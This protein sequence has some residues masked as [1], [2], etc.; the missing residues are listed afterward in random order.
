MR[1][2]GQVTIFLSMILLCMC[3]LLCSI[4]ESA[5]MAGA[6]WYLRMAADSALDSVM[7][8]YHRELWDSYRLLFREFGQPE[9]LEEEFTRYFQPCIGYG[10]WYSGEIEGIDVKLAAMAV[11]EGG[12]FLEEEILDYMKFGIWTMELSPEET[13]D[14]KERLKEAQAVGR[15][16]EIYSAHTREAVK[17]EEALE[18]LDSCLMKQKEKKSQGLEALADGDGGR[19]QRIGRELLKE[20]ERVPRLV[21]TYEKRADDLDRKLARSMARF[22]GESEDM[23]DEAIKLLEQEIGR[24]ESYI[25]KDGERRK[26]IEG[27]IAI[28]EQNRALTEAVMEE[29]EAVEEYIENW[30]GDDEEDELDEEALWRPVRNHFEG[31]REGRITCP[32]GIQDKEKKNTLENLKEMIDRGILGLVIPEEKEVSGKKIQT[33]GLPSAFS[34]GGNSSFGYDGQR[35][36]KLSGNEEK[37]SGLGA[38]GI[39]DRFLVNE[40]CG[41]FFRDFLDEEERP[42]QYEMEYLAAGKDSDNSNLSEAAEE[43]FLIREGLNLLH[44]MSDGGKREEARNLAALIVGASGLAPLVLVTS[45]L[46]MN[47]WAAAEAISDL[48]IMLEE[49][50]VPLWKNPQ[51]WGISLGQMME[52]GR[53]GKVG[54]SQGSGYGLTYTGYLKLLL[55]LRERKVLNYRIMDMVQVNIKD[56]QPDFSMMDCAYGVD[57]EVRVCGKHIFFLPGIVESPIGGREYPMA[58]R[59]RKGY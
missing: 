50:K 47:L 34:R 53:A 51:D 17:V 30:E 36:E 19:F 9:E 38:A 31:F 48:R 8:G 59:V 20:L 45:F 32:H 37:N 58:V 12:S 15:T 10:G 27:E 3:A 4:V 46:I 35:V 40:Y 11:D 55:L 49:G 5:R 22:T 7:A 25:S 13:G 24:Y 57:I 14:L 16:A 28:A 54:N 52:L 33:E 1:K 2:S 6:R 26:E 42:V 44:I 56:K 23:G 41:K 18:N 43:I 39:G 29:A 21:E